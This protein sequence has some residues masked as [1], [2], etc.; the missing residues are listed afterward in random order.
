[1]K[2]DYLM[3]D[4][5][6]PEPA[7]STV[8]DQGQPVREKYFKPGSTIVLRCLV[9]NYRPDFQAPVW[10][11]EDS[12]V[13]DRDRNRLVCSLAFEKIYRLIP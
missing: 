13:T 11:R 12:M 10:R 9:T 1:M 8:D 2:Y 6:F 5:L 4:D 7:L 3:A